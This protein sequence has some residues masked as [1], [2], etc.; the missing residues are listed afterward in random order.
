M[1]HDK[2][3]L[4]FNQIN[5]AVQKLKTLE[6]ADVDLIVDLKQENE[7]LKKDLDH[8]SRTS[9]SAFQCIILALTDIENRYSVDTTRINNMAVDAQTAIQKVCP[10]S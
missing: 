7:K 3:T 1:S 9:W 10:L 6:Q 8:V 4:L 5:S 2:Q